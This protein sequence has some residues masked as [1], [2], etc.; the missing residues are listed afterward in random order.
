MITFILAKVQAPNIGEKYCSKV[1]TKTAFRS[2]IDSKL[3]LKTSWDAKL[4]LT[5][6]LKT[7]Y[8]K[9]IV[10]VMLRFKIIAKT[11]TWQCSWY[12]W[13]KNL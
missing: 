13:F 7:K 10:D 3:Y 6:T 11:T 8:E 12:A 1:K 9:I 2:K 4:M 5:R